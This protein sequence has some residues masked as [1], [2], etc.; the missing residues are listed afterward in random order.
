[1]ENNS[2]L[3]ESAEPETHCYSYCTTSICKFGIPVY[4]RNEVC[5]DPL[6]G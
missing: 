5:T 4:Y 6:T 3:Y 1:M 2:Y